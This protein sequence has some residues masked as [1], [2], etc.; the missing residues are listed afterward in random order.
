MHIVDHQWSLIQKL[1]ERH[2][3][4]QVWSRSGMLRSALAQQPWPWEIVW[5]YL[6]LR[7]FLP[8]WFSRHHQ[9][10][11]WTWCLRT[12]MC[13]FERSHAIYSVVWSPDCQGLR[14]LLQSI[15]PYMDHS[16][17]VLE[18]F[19]TFFR[20]LSLRLK[21][22]QHRNRS[23]HMLHLEASGEHILFACS[24]KI[25]L[26]SIQACFYARWISVQLKEYWVS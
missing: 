13:S 12:N 19:Q 8:R 14:V 15:V 10:V 26:K 23:S 17:A 11:A 22:A 7:V 20:N 24:S 2:I 3:G 6:G 4:T 18:T 25:H 9:T 21:K 16:F 5:R 1:N